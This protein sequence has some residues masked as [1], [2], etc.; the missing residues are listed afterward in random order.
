VQ[1]YL[2]LVEKKNSLLF[3]GFLSNFTP[4][5]SDVNQNKMVTAKCYGV[6]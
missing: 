6:H 4:F 5:K 1:L 2:Q 3:L